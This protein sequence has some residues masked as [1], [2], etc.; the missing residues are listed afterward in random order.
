MLAKQPSSMDEY[1]ILAF[2]RSPS[3]AI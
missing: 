1:R 2:S 3:V